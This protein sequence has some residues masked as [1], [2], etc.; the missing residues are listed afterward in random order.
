MAVGLV[1]VM[2]FRISANRLYPNGPVMALC[3]QNHWDFM[4]VLPRDC[5]PTVWDEVPGLIALDTAD[6]Q[7]ATYHWGDRDQTFRW[8]NAMDYAYRGPTGKTLRQPVCMSHSARKLGWMRTDVRSGR[9]GR[10][11]PVGG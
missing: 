3:R 11:S 4:M 2:T 5:L 7:Y 9:C 6:E 8:V 10:G 1:D